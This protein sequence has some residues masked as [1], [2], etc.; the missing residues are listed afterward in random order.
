MYNNT[1]I[2]IYIYIRSVSFNLINCMM[3][4]LIN[5]INRKINLTVKIPTKDYLN[6][7]V[8]EMRKYHV[9]IT[10]DRFRNTYFI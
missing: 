7:F 9:D 4:C 3:F 2:Y 8:C 1:Y 6:I 10:S 5:L